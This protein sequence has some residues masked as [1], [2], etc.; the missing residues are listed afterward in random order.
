MPSQLG[1]VF[2]VKRL[3]T[4]RK[5]PSE[6]QCCYLTSLYFQ[7][8]SYV[9]TIKYYG[10]RGLLLQSK[11]AGTEDLLC[12]PHSFMEGVSSGLGLAM[13]GS[14]L[15][16]GIIYCLPSCVAQQCKWRLAWEHPWDIHHRCGLPSR[17]KLLLSSETRA[18][19]PGC[20]QCNG[21]VSCCYPN[22][23]ARTMK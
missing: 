15:I 14:H 7:S 22:I 6:K 9:Y 12:T 18:K 13:E 2:R 11:G 20:R 17:I 10:Q 4:K 3:G 23:L 16:G 19:F 1:E 8:R 5:Q 21:I